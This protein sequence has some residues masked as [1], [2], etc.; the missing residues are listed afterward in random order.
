MLKNN[1]NIII[2]ATIIFIIIAAIVCSF[3]F[4]KN[5]ID[6]RKDFSVESDKN[7]VTF[8]YDSKKYEIN[9]NNEIYSVDGTFRMHFKIGKE[10]IERLENRRKNLNDAK[11]KYDVKMVNFNGYKGYAKIDKKYGVFEINLSLNK[12]KKNPVSVVIR[13]LPLNLQK[14][15]ER[16]KNGENPEDILYNLSDVQK[17]LHSIKYSVK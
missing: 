15:N 9:K 6:N 10:T 4:K 17:I 7:I 3:I 1:K 12:D 11:D 2:V 5:N 14:A 8:S 16:I 13:T